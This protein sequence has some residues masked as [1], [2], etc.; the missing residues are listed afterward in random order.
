[1][2]IL[3]KL[4]GFLK[5]SFEDQMYSPPTAAELEERTVRATFVMDY[6]EKHFYD[7]QKAM[8]DDAA[9]TSYRRF[10]VGGVGY[11]VDEKSDTW[12][13]ETSG[14]LSLGVTP[15]GKGIPSSDMDTAIQV[16]AA[17]VAEAYL[18]IKGEEV[19]DQLQSQPAATSLTNG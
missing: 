3:K 4:G 13:P 15:D 8:A 19:Y 6:A 9:V 7:T 10:K 2:N 18:L 1:M 17:R 5:G 12:V 11:V 14:G 16:A